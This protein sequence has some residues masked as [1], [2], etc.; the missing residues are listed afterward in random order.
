MRKQMLKQKILGIIVVG[1]R[2]GENSLS[3]NYDPIP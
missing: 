3:V 2:I 1:R